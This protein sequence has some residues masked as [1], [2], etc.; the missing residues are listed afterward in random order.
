MLGDI[1]SSAI[2]LHLS[3]MMIVVSVCLV[4]LA[5]C[6]WLRKLKGLD[7]LKLDSAD[8]TISGH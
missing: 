6:S 5:Y 3:V 4:T 2:L 1:D 7:Q 8:G